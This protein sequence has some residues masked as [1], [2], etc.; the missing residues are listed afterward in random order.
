LGPLSTQRRL[1]L[2]RKKTSDAGGGLP[3]GI[4]LSEKYP[5]GV[6]PSQAGLTLDQVDLFFENTG[7]D[8]HE[9]SPNNGARCRT[10]QGSRHGVDR[11]GQPDS[12][13]RSGTGS[14]TAWTIRTRQP[15]SSWSTGGSPAV[16]RGTE[17]P[18]D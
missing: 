7:S 1:A 2:S 10:G 4:L 6:S 13:I 11:G 18:G 14:R 5:A 16:S 17:Q 9:F 15:A 8:C 3:T 12:R